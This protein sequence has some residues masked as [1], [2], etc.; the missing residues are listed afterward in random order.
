MVKM[1]CVNL[2]RDF[3]LIRF[4]STKDYDHV[5]C[6]GPWFIGEQFLAIMLWEP[7]FKAKQSFPQL[8]FGLGFLNCQ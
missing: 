5:L 4:S 8:Q 1:D 3:F 7:Y 2:G 6:G